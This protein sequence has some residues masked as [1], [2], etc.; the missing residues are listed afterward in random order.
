MPLFTIG[1]KHI[2]EIPNAFYILLRYI[3]QW[4]KIENKII[5]FKRRW[6]KT[7]GNQLKKIAYNL[8]FYVL[9]L[10]IYCR[11]SHVQISNK[12]RSA[13]LV[14]LTIASSQV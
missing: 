14:S 10:D 6:Y 11:Y 5:E 1:M 12:T 9:F 13:L 2:P 7:V 8:Y 4:M 3:Y